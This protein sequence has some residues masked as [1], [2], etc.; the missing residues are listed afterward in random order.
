[1]TRSI[2]I[3][4]LLYQ[5]PDIVCANSKCSVEAVRKLG[6]SELL[7]FAYAG[8]K[9]GKF[10]QSA[11]F[12]Q[13]PCLHW[14]KKKLTKH[15]VILMIRGDSSGFSLFTNV[16]PNLPDDH[17]YLTLPCMYR[18]I[19]CI[20]MSFLNPSK[21][22]PLRKQGENDEKKTSGRFKRASTTYEIEIYFVADYSVYT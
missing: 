17:S 20:M 15:Q 7:L 18:N 21:A 3:G 8:V 14:I 16:C 13:R 6:W 22:D 9:S 5:L 4:L 12:G 10:G 2:N 1:M 19:L 11:K